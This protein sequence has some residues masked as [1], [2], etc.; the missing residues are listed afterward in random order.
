MTLVYTHPA[1][2]IVAQA[3]ST[4]ELAT[5][6]CMIRNEYAAGAIGELA[7]IDA[8]PELWVLRDRDFERAQQLLEDAGKDSPDADWQCHS[9]GSSSPST[10]EL[11]WHCAGE[12]REY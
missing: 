5:I 3:R 1:C 10:F 4:L 7:P 6:D 9:C 11:C 2:I 8:W 12:K